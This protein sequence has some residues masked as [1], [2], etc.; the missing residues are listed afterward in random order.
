MPEAII[1][2]PNPPV[3]K[4]EDKPAAADVT[5]QTSIPDQYKGEKFWEAY[6]DKPLGEVLKST[7]ESQ[8]LI[9]RSIQ[10]PDE[11]ADPKIK[12]EQM[13]KIYTRL[14][15]PEKAEGYKTDE[16]ILLPDGFEWVPDQI[17]GFAE[18]AHKLGM[19]D[20]QYNGI[21]GFYAKMLKPY[22]QVSAQK[23]VRETL[24]KEWGEN[25][26]KVKTAEGY[27]AARIYLGNEAETW[28]KTPR[29]GAPGDDPY[30]IRLL[31]KVGRELREEGIIDD[32]LVE[33]AKT[34]ADYEAEAKKIIADNEDPYNKKKHPMHQQR[35]DYVTHLFELS[36]V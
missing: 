10:M 20:A 24:E 21:L 33:G 28:L 3:Q 5:W 9:G 13:E 31:A 12:S 25:G 30:V 17:K 14:G 16:T 15:R 27:A 32:T 36:G 19:N 26:Y 7:M 18:H 4:V 2:N 8:K 29:E 23:E 22:D 35:V 34:S 6:K 11:K 1:V